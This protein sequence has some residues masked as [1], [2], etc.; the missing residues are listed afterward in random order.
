[1]VRFFNI[2]LFL[3]VFAAWTPGGAG[4]ESKRTKPWRALHLLDYNSDLLW[5][6]LGRILKTSPTLELT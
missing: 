1:M 4:V 6:R 2:V 3:L 5:M